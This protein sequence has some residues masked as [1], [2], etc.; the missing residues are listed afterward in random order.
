MGWW[1]E[2]GPKCRRCSEYTAGCED[3]KGE[4]SVNEVFSRMECSTCAGT[5]WIC[6]ANDHG[7]Y[8]T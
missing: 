5:G 3:C 4:G 2:D 6:K 7:K 1:N 8:W